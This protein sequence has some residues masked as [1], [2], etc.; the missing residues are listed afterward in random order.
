VA[1]HG[2]GMY[3]KEMDIL[4]HTLGRGKFPDE[5]PDPCKPGPVRICEMHFRLFDS[6]VGSSSSPTA[7]EETDNQTI[8]R[9]F[10]RRRKPNAE[11][12][13]SASV[14][15]LRTAAATD[16]G[17]EHE[18]WIQIHATNLSL[19]GDV[20]DGRRRTMHFVMVS[21]AVQVP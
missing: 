8:F 5:Q 18:R 2:E 15:R 19:P 14:G 7:L 20:N 11:K 4:P 21:L 6:G 16:V 3:L 9:R 13:I 1:C 12:T 17:D 10:I